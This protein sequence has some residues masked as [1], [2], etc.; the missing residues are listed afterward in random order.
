MSIDMKARLIC[1]IVS[2]VR[3]VL[4]MLAFTLSNFFVSFLLGFF[5]ASMTVV[6]L[7]GAI[8]DEQ[9]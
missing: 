1:G 2:I 9:W 8:D 4:I 7:I 3:A 6:G 5:G